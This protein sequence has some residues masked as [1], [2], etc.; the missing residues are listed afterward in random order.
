MKILMTGGTG[1][2]GMNLT[3][4]LTEAGHQVTLLT[5]S[6]KRARYLPAG[7]Y[8]LEGDPV[9]PGAWQKEVGEHEGIIN[10]AGSSI[11]TRWTKSVKEAM[12]NSRIETTKNLIESMTSHRG[13]V[14]FLLSTSAVGYYGS[15]EDE[16]VDERTPPGDDFLASLARDWEETALKAEGLGVRVVI[17]RFGVVL[18][19]GGGALGQMLPLFKRY[20]GSPL[21][22]GRQWFSWIHEDDL[23]QM[24]FFLLE[25]GD[26]RGPVNCTSPNPV[27]NQE[28]TR[29][30]GRVIGRP[31]FMPAVPGFII[32]MMMG[33]FG[34]VLLRGQKVV[35]RRL[36]EMGFTFQYPEIDK[37][38][39]NLV[40]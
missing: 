18:G 16:E 1:F 14:K 9:K 6:A 5:R 13:K 38:L 17:F 27:R 3:S 15:H 11:F 40:A 25:R 10:L 20:L 24:Y 35:P 19:R 28:L 33:E 31:T 21:G 23:V 34:S 29:I 8:Y 30:L 37:A 39:E 4:R 12:R 7:A 32:K 36:L 22:S 2:V 26:I